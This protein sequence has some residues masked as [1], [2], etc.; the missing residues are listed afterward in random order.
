MQIQIN[1]GAGVPVSEA[2]EQHIMDRLG[3]LDRR[4]GERLT[5]IEVHMV[6]VNGPKG[7][8]N[9][10][11]R[12]EARPKGMDPVIASATAESAYDAVSGAVDKL[13]KVLAS[14]F[15]KK[16]SRRPAAPVSQ[17]EADDS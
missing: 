5:R 9:K 13:E 15:G 2:F 16:D 14:R 8:E 11:V 4:F 1:P 10:Q 17:E 3:R 12:V 6:D 7:G